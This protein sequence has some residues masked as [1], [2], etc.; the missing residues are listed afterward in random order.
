MYYLTINHEGDFVI[1]RRSK[2]VRKGENPYVTAC[3]PKTVEEVYAFFADEV[4][5]LNCDVTDFTIMSSSS[6]D[7]PADSTDKQYVLDICAALA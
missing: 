5:R 7:F 6:I 1:Q 3:T 4:V 2:V